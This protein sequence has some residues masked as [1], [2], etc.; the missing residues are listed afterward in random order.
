MEFP[1]K[2]NSQYGAA[3][4]QSQCVFVYQFA[5]FRSDLFI[6]PPPDLTVGEIPECFVNVIFFQD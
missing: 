1:K 3:P 6:S 2:A 4:S 5:W